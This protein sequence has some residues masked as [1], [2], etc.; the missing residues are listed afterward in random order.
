MG[1]TLSDV[2]AYSVLIPFLISCIRFSKIRESYYPFIFFIVA[3]FLAELASELTIGAGVSNNIVL[4]TFSLL[5]AYFITWQFRNWGLFERYKKLFAVLLVFYSV[6]WL[7]ENLN[8]GFTTRV[9]SYFLI[10][11]SFIMALMSINII[12][13]L[14]IKEHGALWKNPAFLICIGWLLYFTFSVLTESFFLYGVAT[15]NPLFATR[16]YNIFLFVNIFTNFV[17]VIAILCIPT[18][19]KF[20]LPS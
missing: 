17:F 13:K 16:V 14:A 4:N 9:N 3:G 1:L 20:I 12:N 15:K 2:S 8:S 11:S 19:P 6:F 5:Q 7:V 18:K 10:I